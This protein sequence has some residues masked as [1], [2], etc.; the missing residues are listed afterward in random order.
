M[1]FSGGWV[2]G[3]VRNTREN[4]LQAQNLNGYVKRLFVSGGGVGGWLTHQQFS[5][6]QV[7]QN[8]KIS[9]E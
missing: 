1:S 3:V 8:L 2:L 9:T 5:R 7:L 6:N 4:R